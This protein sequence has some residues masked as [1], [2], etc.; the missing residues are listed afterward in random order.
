MI[1]TDSELAYEAPEELAVLAL[2]LWTPGAFAEIAAHGVTAAMFTRTTS[3][4]LWQVLAD[5]DAGPLGIDELEAVRVLEGRTGDGRRLV[6]D[7]AGLPAPARS[8]L[9]QY[10]GTVAERHQL[11]RIVNDLAALSADALAGAPLDTVRARLTDVAERPAIDTGLPADLLDLDDLARLADTDA[12][13]WVLP[14]LLPEAGRLIVVAEEGAGKSSLLRQLAMTAAA[15]LHPFTATRTTTPRRV[16]VIDAENNPATARRPGDGTLD[17][18]SFAGMARALAGRVDL[19]ATRDRLRVWSRPAGIDL[20]SPAAL[21]PLERILRRHRPELV[22]AGP[23]YR[24]FPRRTN[25]TDETLAAEAQLVL[26]RLRSRFDFALI[27]E[28]HAPQAAAGST[29]ELRPYGS[30]LWLRWP[31]LGF[32]L[33][34]ITDQTGRT[35]GLAPRG[36]RENRYAANWPPEIV[37]NPT[38]PL[39]FTVRDPAGNAGR[40]LNGAP[41]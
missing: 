12:P 17:P 3:A 5:L 6:A 16:L 15:G 10:A 18:T 9:A 25:E 28:H 13:P 32:G 24:L 30:S 27:L 34:R 40:H 31:D 21:G 29:R 11:R 26:D 33:R 1:P 23:V 36:F 4:E 8:R 20:R 22:I 19:D 39:P 35:V 41:R 37:R 38:G 2:A 14:G 7:L